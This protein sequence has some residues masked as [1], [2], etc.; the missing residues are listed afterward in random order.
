M[1]NSNVV[2]LALTRR[3]H[4]QYCDCWSGLVMFNRNVFA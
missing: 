1:S 3:A 2:N 4:L